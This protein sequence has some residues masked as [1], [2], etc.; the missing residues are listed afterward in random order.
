M[1]KEVTMTKPLQV[2][3][4]EWKQRDGTPIRLVDMDDNHLFNTIRMLERKAE[5]R[6]KKAD[7]FQSFDPEDRFDNS[8]HMFLPPI[9]EVMVAM[10][11]ARGIKL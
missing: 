4:T 1:P 5:A 3:Y 9:Y 6:C 8:P 7:K 11:T 2:E 10:A